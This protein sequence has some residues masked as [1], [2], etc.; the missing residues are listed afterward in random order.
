MTKT[1][2]WCIGCTHHPLHHKRKEFNWIT[3]W[4]PGEII[5][6]IGK[7]QEQGKEV[8]CLFPIS[9]AFYDLDLD[10]EKFTYPITAYGD[11]LAITGHQ[12]RGFVLYAN[13]DNENHEE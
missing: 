8:D 10:P 9:D 6:A 5:F 1:V 13:C 2:C 3:G 4:E 7:D 12:G 11:G